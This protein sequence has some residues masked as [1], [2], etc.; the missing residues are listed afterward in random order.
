MLLL[1][2]RMAELFD[3]VIDEGG[4]VDTDYRH[5]RIHSAAGGT[6][7]IVAVST[8]TATRTLKYGRSPGTFRN[9]SLRRHE[10]DPDRELQS[11]PFRYRML[12][13][14][15]VSSSIGR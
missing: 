13:G 14:A 9:V 5:R 15:N 2:V 10:S 6:L 4:T 8:R 12:R 1:L 11:A 3:L 7:F